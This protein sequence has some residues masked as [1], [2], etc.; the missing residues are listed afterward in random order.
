MTSRSSRI[1]DRSSLALICIEESRK[2]NSL[3]IACR[4]ERSPPIDVI[5]S[6]QFFMTNFPLRVPLTHRH[7]PSHSHGEN[8][9]RC[10]CLTYFHS[11]VFHFLSLFLRRHGVEERRRTKRNQPRK[12]KML[13]I[14][15]L[16]VILRLPCLSAILSHNFSRA[17]THTHARPSAGSMLKSVA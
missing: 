6:I 13:I 11:T 3:S 1:I 14:D 10:V 2:L 9:Q 12:W 15:F 17:F 4:S 8:T 5:E 7:A 16:N